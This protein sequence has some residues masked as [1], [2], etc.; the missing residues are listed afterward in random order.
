MNFLRT[1]GP[2][3]CC[4]NTWKTFL[5][6][7][8]AQSHVDHRNFY[9][10]TDELLAF[11][12]HIRPIR[13]TNS[14]T[15]VTDSSFGIETAA[16]TPPT[17]QCLNQQLTLDLEKR[18]AFRDC[19]TL[20]DVCTESFVWF[21]RFTDYLMSTHFS[22]VSLKQNLL[23]KNVFKLTTFRCLLTFLCLFKH[24]LVKP[25]CCDA[26]MLTC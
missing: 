9:L 15:A 7:S 10:W 25:W 3:A 8:E 23:L 14:P 2:W 13:A 22:D 19:W 4:R 12:D 5:L 6:L 20:L 21:S 16:H 26:N 11:N 17:C 18:V 24:R 1:C